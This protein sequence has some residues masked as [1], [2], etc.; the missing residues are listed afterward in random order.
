MSGDVGTD[1][2]RRRL[3]AD[4]YRPAYHFLPPANWM[5]D[6]NG[7]IF[8]QG[9]YHLFYQYNPTGAYWHDPYWGH[10]VSADLV[11]WTDLPPALAPERGGADERGCFSGMAFIDKDGVPTI[12]YYGN[13]RGLC[14][15]TSRDDDLVRWEKHPA[16]PVL[17]HPTH[18]ED[19]QVFDPCAWLEGDTYYAITGGIAPKRAKGIPSDGRDVAY[20]FRSNDLEDWEYLHPF[21]E[22]SR[23]TEGGEDCAVPDFFPFG[24]KH[25]L[26]FCS[27]TRAAQCYIGTYA[28]HRFIPEHHKRF[29]F[30]ETGRIGVV[31]EGLTLVDGQGRRI[32]FGRISEARYG[33]AQ[34]AAGWAGILALPMVLSPAEDGDV[35]IEPVP[36][37]AALR[38]DYAHV[39]DIELPPDRAVALPEVRGDRLEIRAIFEWETAEEFGLAVRCSPDGDEQTLIRFNTNP[40]VRNWPPRDLPPHRELIL[41]VTRSSM[42]PEVSNRES[43]RCIVELPYGQPLELRVFI[44]RSVVEVF[45]NRRH[46]LAKRIYPA[47][48]D[49]LGVR[50]YAAGGSATLR[51][52]ETWH[53]EAI[54]PLE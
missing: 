6:P 19:Y 22:S 52:L 7:P 43:Q 47:R 46:Y 27:H 18:G 30:A 41:D 51:S 34:R 53:M 36:E 48:S 44:D 16:N 5:N 13:P 1:P 33:Y 50:L 37:L 31:G 17:P 9:K 32:L 54:W 10:A 24:D 3:G 12:I 35:L 42:S 38:R 14:I 20:L 11:H 26:L 40:R 21:Y 2:D 28:N 45:A 8:W 39:A 4:P 49:S 29:A 23:F 15:A 25:M